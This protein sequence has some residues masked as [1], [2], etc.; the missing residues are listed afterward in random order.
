[1]KATH[2]APPLCARGSPAADAMSEAMDRPWMMYGTC[3]GMAGVYV[4]S[5][6]ALP[7]LVALARTGRWAPLLPRDH[8]RTVWARL[9]CASVATLIDVI[10]TCRVLAR[11][12]LISTRQPFRCLDALAWLGL[13]TPRLSFLVSHWLPFHPSL[14]AT[15]LQGLR[16]IG[17]ATLL[18]S[19]LY[20][21][22]FW[23]D[24]QAQALPGQAGYYD[25]TG[26]RPSLLYLRNYVIVRGDR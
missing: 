22:T 5:L 19:L 6:H 4:G 13:P 1:M 21:G 20:L 11:H 23:T 8:P 18:T 10:W 12:G 17:N 16:I 2:P 7:Q 9:W 26:P 15:L 25:E 14:S 3:W 24:L